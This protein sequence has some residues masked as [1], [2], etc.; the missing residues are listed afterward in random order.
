MT[1]STKTADTTKTADSP[2]TATPE[3]ATP[4]TFSAVGAD[5]LATIDKLVCKPDTEGAQSMCEQIE[6]EL[7]GHASAI[8]VSLVQASKD[9][10]KPGDHFVFH[11]Q[12]AAQS[13][14]AAASNFGVLIHT[15]SGTKGWLEKAVTHEAKEKVA[16]K[17]QA[18]PA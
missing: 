2:K 8:D 1:E 18:K 6:A 14:R 10:H 7:L 15:F 17:A 9:G 12:K 3:P 11:A 13:L 16:I 5:V 4:E